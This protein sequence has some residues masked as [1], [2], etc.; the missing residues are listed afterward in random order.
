MC[1]APGRAH[2]DAS[3]APSIGLARTARLA[4]R[5]AVARDVVVGIAVHA[6][7]HARPAGCRRAGVDLDGPPDV[8][9]YDESL[10]YVRFAPFGKRW[11]DRRGSGSR[12]FDSVREM[13]WRF[14]LSRSS[15]PVFGVFRPDVQSG[16]RGAAR[17]W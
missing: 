11:V 14:R 8:G 13:E 12:E 3:R 4:D 15:I 10:T 6:F 17:P 2:G 1:E 16:V 9:L 7:H 5:E